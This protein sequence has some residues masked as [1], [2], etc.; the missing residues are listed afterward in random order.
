[1]ARIHDKLQ[2]TGNVAIVAVQINPNKE[3]KD[4]FELR[5]YGGAS[6]THR[7]S[8]IFNL[9]KGSGS[10]ILYVQKFK[11]PDPKVYKMFFDHR[12]CRPFRVYY[13]GGLMKPITN[14]WEHRDDNDAKYE[15]PDDVESRGA[16]PVK[17][18]G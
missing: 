17:T 10:N 18:G 2:G 16:L 7:P 3:S 1:M 15:L 4:N 13:E 9:V 11:Q 6:L 5:A 14:F 8:T 12:W